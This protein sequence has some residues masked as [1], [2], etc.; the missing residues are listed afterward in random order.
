MEIFAYGNG[1]K[2]LLNLNFI[3][4]NSEFLNFI[5]EYF[6]LLCK[7]FIPLNASFI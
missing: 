3:F 2:S 6:I 4:L 7:I 1:S 5:A